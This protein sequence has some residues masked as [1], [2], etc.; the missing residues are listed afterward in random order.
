MDAMD[1]DYL[2][3]LALGTAKL[4]QKKCFE[5]CLVHPETERL[6]GERTDVP[7]PSFLP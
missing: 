6:K 7:F 2:S 4:L 3:R 5:T 1:G